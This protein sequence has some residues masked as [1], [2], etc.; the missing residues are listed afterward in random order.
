MQIFICCFFDIPG[1]FRGGS[2][3]PLMQ[4]PYARVDPP[5]PRNQLLVRGGGGS[6]PPPR[7]RQLLRRVGGVDLPPG[8]NADATAAMSW[9]GIAPTMFEL[10]A[11]IPSR[12]SKHSARH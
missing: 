12:T 7:Q 8:T 6:T 5:R 2:T 3:P 4:L 9:Q 1:R 11:L 10:F